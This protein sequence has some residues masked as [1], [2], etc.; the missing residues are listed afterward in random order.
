ME[1]NIL[2]VNLIGCTICQRESW[3]QTASE[4]GKYLFDI[5]L[6]RKCRN[7]SREL[8]TSEIMKD[9]ILNIDIYRYTLQASTF[10]MAVL[11]QYNDA[12]QWTMSQLAESTQIKKDILVQVN[13]KILL[14]VSERSVIGALWKTPL[15]EISD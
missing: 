6:N 11:L 15:N 13:L 8:S 12:D 1:D 2:V 4:T 10:Q 7:F 9:F 3:L 14:V 5:Q